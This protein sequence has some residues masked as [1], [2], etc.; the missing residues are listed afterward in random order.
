[1]KKIIII[2]LV[3]VLTVAMLASCKK[4]T[5]LLQNVPVDRAAYL[6]VVHV[7][8]GFTKVFNAPDNFN[9]VIGAVNGTRMAAA[10]TYNSVF[11][12]NTLNTNTYAAVPSG[13]QDIRLVLKGVV[14]IDSNTVVT[15]PKNLNPGWYYTLIITDSITTTADFSKIWITDNFVPPASGNYSVRFIHAAMND[16]AGK[17]VDLYSTKQAATIFSNVAPGDVSGFITFPITTTGSTGDTVIIRRAGTSFEL[18]R[19]PRNATGQ[20]SAISYTNNQRVY[21][22]LYKG[23]ATFLSTT[24]LPKGRSIYVWNNR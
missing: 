18:D 19:Y 23:D 17:K 16:T 20:P 22:I 4:Y 1:M 2:P 12:S 15:I 10:M 11:P 3:T 21:T 24:L 14:N 5:R 13:S 8:P 6:K 7:A 9:V